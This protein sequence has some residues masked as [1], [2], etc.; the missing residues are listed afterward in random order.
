MA[1][2]KD[3]L[4]DQLDKQWARARQ[5]ENQRAQM[6]NFLIVIYG[7]LQGFIVQRK[8]DEPTI[9]LACVMILLGIFGVLASFK[10]YERFRLSTCRVGRI[11]ERLK[12]LEPLA[13]LEE[14]EAVADKKH[15]ARY[16]RLVRL[17][18]HKLWHALHFG[19][20]ILGIVNLL[21]ILLAPPVF[22]AD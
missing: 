20:I 8:F 7:V 12:E 13:N 2:V 3:I 6:T 10:Y 5:S 18:L 14:L 22:T 1:D 9:I 17:R 19:I 15:Q 16:P 11:M 21:I 4:L